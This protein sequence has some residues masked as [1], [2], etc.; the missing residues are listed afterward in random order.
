MVGEFALAL[1]ELVGNI[2]VHGYAGDGSSVV[3][4]RI[5]FESDWL[6]ATLRDTASPYNP[7]STPA[8]DPDLAL[9]ERKIGGLGVH[10]ARKRSDRDLSTAIRLARTS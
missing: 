9:D 10:L 1:D 3:D 6:T 4:I 8:V 5:E 7:L 2:L